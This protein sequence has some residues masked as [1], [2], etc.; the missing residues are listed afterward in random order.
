MEDLKS[1]LKDLLT[2]IEYKHLK[3]D[4]VKQVTLAG[5]DKS[6]AQKV[7][8]EIGHIVDEYER[9]LRYLI[10]LLQTENSTDVAQEL[11]SW[12]AY[13]RDITIWK[14]DDALVQLDG[15][16][17]EYLLSDPEMEDTEQQKLWQER[18]Y[19]ATVKLIMCVYP[20]GIPHRQYM[21]LL[22]ILEK[23]MSIRTLAS[24][25][26]HIRGGHE[27]VYLDDVVFANNY[28]PS[29]AQQD[30]VMSKLQACGYDEWLAEFK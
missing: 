14:L 6:E 20:H 10:K 13:T 15:K 3:Q 25:I 8:A 26:A 12:V 30:Y 19:N 11:E 2:E 1:R 27:T 5:I 18:F 7:A 9:S 17:E 21:T 16:F 29:K 23:N 24:I 4:W 22:S 28:H